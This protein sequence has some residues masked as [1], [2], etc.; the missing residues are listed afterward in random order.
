VLFFPNILRANSSDDQASAE[1]ASAL[2]TP[3]LLKNDKKA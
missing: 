2:P 3:D 1:E